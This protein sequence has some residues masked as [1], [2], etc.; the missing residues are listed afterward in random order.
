MILS[1]SETMLYSI[2]S[3][4]MFN[5]QK[6]KPKY[7]TKV[8]PNSP[9]YLSFVCSVTHCMLADTT[10]LGNF[11]SGKMRRAKEEIETR[12]PSCFLLFPRLFA[13]EPQGF[14]LNGSFLVSM[15]LTSKA[16][17]VT[18]I[19]SAKYCFENIQYSYNKLFLLLFQQ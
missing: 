14:I 3:L 8:A 5:A 7:I 16:D 6:I 10:K 4:M 13:H 18:A 11:K 15:K 12:H 17:F 1:T 9:I 2:I 19:K